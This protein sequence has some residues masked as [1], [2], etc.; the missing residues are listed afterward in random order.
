MSKQSQV[1]TQTAIGIPGSKAAANAFDYYPQSL[2]AETDVTAGTF[3]W[4]GTDPAS[5]AKPA[6][7]GRPL[8][9][10]ERNIVYPNYDVL[11]EGSLVIEAGETLTI[12]TQG[13]FYAVSATAATVGQKVFA[14]LADG[15]IKTGAAGATISG[16]VET[17]WKVVTPGA[18]GEVIVIAASAMGDITTIITG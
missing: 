17:A 8:G 4:P 7:T 2:T 12:A 10:V 3:V 14:V 1:Y 6:G 11:S 18:I 13:A 15:T 9:L 5:Q 16:A